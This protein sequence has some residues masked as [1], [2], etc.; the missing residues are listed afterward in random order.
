MMTKVRKNILLPKVLVEKVIEL[1]EQKGL[2]QSEIIT[3][4]IR[5]YVKHE[6]IDYPKL[7][8]SFQLMFKE[9]FD[10]FHE[11][12]KRIRFALNQ[13]AKES[14]YNIEFWNDHFLHFGN[15]E[16]ITTDLKKANELEQVEKTILNKILKAQQ[17]KYS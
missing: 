9:N 15:G 6:G 17:R 10:D 1:S 8:E 14:R 5:Y 16:I 11:E 7:S 4:A 13:I 2:S 3:D 12:L